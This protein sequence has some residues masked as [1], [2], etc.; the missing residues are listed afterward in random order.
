MKR[1][2]GG[3]FA[4]GHGPDVLDRYTWDQLGLMAE[5]IGLHWVGLLDMVFSPLAGAMGG[6]YTSGAVE[7]NSRKAPRKMGPTEI[8]RTDLD[9]VKRAKDRDA[10]ILTMAGQIPGVE[11]E[12]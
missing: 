2:L 11:I 12:L 3:L 9:A 4:S 1:V 7:T 8:D 10:R 5:C 6:T